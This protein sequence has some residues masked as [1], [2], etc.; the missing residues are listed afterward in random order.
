MALLQGGVSTVVC[1]LQEIE[2]STLFGERGE[3]VSKMLKNRILLLSVS[4]LLLPIG[5]KGNIK[6][7]WRYHFCKTLKATN[8]TKFFNTNPCY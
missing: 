3:N 4:T 6:A 2:K 7:S 1:V 8:F 5:T